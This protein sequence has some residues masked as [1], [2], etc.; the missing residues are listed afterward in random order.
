MK[1]V[2]LHSSETLTSCL[3]LARFLLG[4]FFIPEKGACVFLR[5]ADFRLILDGYLFH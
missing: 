2:A 5:K 3:L 4:S 1:M